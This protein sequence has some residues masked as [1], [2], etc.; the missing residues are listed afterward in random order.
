MRGTRRLQGALCQ[1]GQ[2]GRL[3]LRLS[4]GRK[5]YRYVQRSVF[6]FSYSQ[7]SARVMYSSNLGTGKAQILCNRWMNLGAN[8]KKAGCLSQSSVTIQIMKLRHHV[9][10][11]ATCMFVDIDFH[12]YYFI[13]RITKL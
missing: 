2:P 12:V 7:R 6:T 11:I 13:L 9:T 10:Y 3:P 4:S 1:A 8:L 5:L